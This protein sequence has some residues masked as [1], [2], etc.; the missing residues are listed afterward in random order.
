M[1]I[2]NMANSFES[3]QVMENKV[4]N[5]EKEAAI[6]KWN[7]IITKMKDKQSG[8]IVKSRRIRLRIYENSFTANEAVDWMMN[9]LQVG[10]EEAVIIGKEL[11]RRGFINHVTYRGIFEDNKDLIFRFSEEDYNEEQK[12][13]HKLARLESRKTN[14]KAMDLP[15]QA[16]YY[17]IY[18]NAV[19]DNVHII[20]SVHNKLNLKQMEYLKSLSS[21]LPNCLLRDFVIN[22]EVVQAP[23]CQNLF[24]SVLFA[25]I[26]GFTPLCEMCALQGARGV[27]TLTKYL[28]DYFGQMINLILNHG[29]D[30]VKF[31]GDALVAIFPTSNVDGLGYCSLLA[32]Q[33]A[34][35]MQEHLHQYKAGENLLTLH[36]GI[37]AGEMAAIV[38][39]GVNNRL[40]FLIAGN[41]MDQ[42]A[43]C[44]ASAK[45]G[46]VYISY[47]AASLIQDQIQL[48]IDVVSKKSIKKKKVDLL[49]DNSTCKIFRLDKII[50]S[51]PLPTSIQITHF[52][53]MKKC[54]VPFLQPAVLS[55]LDSGSPDDFLSE[56]RNV[57][58]VF[59]KIDLRYSHKNLPSLQQTFKIIQ[60]TILQFEGT[61][62]QFIID[63]KGSVAISAFGLPPLSHEDDPWRA[64]QASLMIM[65]KIDELSIKTSVGITT[66]KAFC[67]AVGSEERREYAMVGD[68][69]NLSARLMSITEGS[70][71]VDYSTYLSS[72]SRIDFVK[73]PAILF[74]GKTQPIDVY[75]PTKHSNHINQ[76]LLQPTDT[77]PQNK[78]KFLTSRSLHSHIYGRTQIMTTFNNL[79]QWLLDPFE[80]DTNCRTVLIEGEP[81]LG[82]TFLLGHLLKKMSKKKLTY[83][84][85]ST[86]SIEANTPYFVWKD[87]LSALVCPNKSQTNEQRQEDALHYLHSTLSPT[88][89]PYLSL[90]NSLFSLELKQSEVCSQMTD[91]LGGEMLHSLLMDLVVKSHSHVIVID[92]AQW[93]DHASWH[94]LYDIIQTLKQTLVVV[95]MRPFDSQPSEIKKIVALDQTL[96]HT[97]TPLSK[98]DLH[99]AACQKLSIVSIAPHIVDHLV[100]KSAGNPLMLNE[101]CE[102]L[103]SQRQIEI[104]NNGDCRST[105]RFKK[106]SSLLGMPSTLRSLITAKVDR[107]PQ[108]Q[109]FLLKAASVIGKIFQVELLQHL[110]YKVLKLE[111]FTEVSFMASLDA[112]ETSEFINVY[113][114]APLSYVFQQTTTLEVIYDL[115]LFSQ[116]NQIHQAIA[117]WLELHSAL[118]L[119]K[120]Y[121][122]LAHHY[123]KAQV[124]DKA[125][126]YYAQ[127]GRDALSK[128]AN[129]EALTF[130]NESIQL[131]LNL[132]PELAQKQDP[133]LLLSSYRQLGQAFYNLGLFE[134]AAQTLEEALLSINEPVRIKVGQE[135]LSKLKVDKKNNQNQNQNQNIVHQN[136]NPHIQIPYK[137]FASPS[138]K[139]KKKTSNYNSPTYNS[140]ITL[141]E[142][143]LILLTLGKVSYYSCNRQTMTYCNLQ[144][145]KFAE[146]LAQTFELC[147]AYSGCILTC[148]IHRKY[149]EALFYIELGRSLIDV[150]PHSFKHSDTYMNLL[151]A[152]GMY[153]TGVHEW[154]EAERLF[155]K[156]IKIAKKVGNSR[157]FEESSI[158]LS[159]ALFLQGKIHQSQLL[160][161]EAVVYAKKRGDAQSQVLAF[162]A[163]ARNWLALGYADKALEALQFLEKVV[164]HGEGHK[165]DVSNE[166]NFHA[167]M[168]LVYLHQQDFELA[169]KTAETIFNF[170]DFCEPTTFFTFTAYMTIP[171]VISLFIMQTSNLSGFKLQTNL[172]FPLLISKLEKALKHLSLFSNTFTFSEPRL[173]FW[174]GFLQFLNSKH[175]RALAIWKQSLALAK[176]YNMLYDQG[177]VLYRIGKFTDVKDNHKTVEEKMN[178]YDKALDIFS[179]IGLV[180][181]E[182]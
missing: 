161:Q 29:G 156:V 94:L 124:F 42:V 129:K 133:N 118:D 102:S 180:Y 117:E 139:F 40:E 45:P 41:P 176:K 18:W 23:S 39:G 28:N 87:M 8:I 67:G 160:T 95:A 154:N 11:Q 141:K 177:I 20:S 17:S 120:S 27:E 143:I 43:A 75:S 144:A 65:L 85:G 70:L 98:D 163:Q 136:S 182:L 167:L 19:H 52:K 123:G 115:M 121:P 134:K 166:I 106:H 66:G 96:C 110:V 116:K 162:T 138:Y 145:L 158:F 14:S 146:E 26:S 63:D 181:T 92:N 171:Q 88:F 21:Y 30:I 47:E 13:V 112:L 128:Y 57:S 56:L 48:S 149:Q 90:L 51:I 60:E 153:Y 55:H 68:V 170:I 12:V 108:N 62:R 81:G 97:L 151:Q 130:F 107:I 131:N 165:L 122:L 59:C 84:T 33:C 71:L 64:V 44:E 168:A 77:I 101:L 148:A 69:V 37:G 76:H 178:A 137:S 179:E 25:D 79:F 104:N 147:E 72:K 150:S 35:A 36:I 91:E 58:V 152:S 1:K 89:F 172:S 142:H 53:N 7:Q 140:N 32:A 46:Q 9:Q 111:T 169:Y 99:S 10:R 5:N 34:L 6:V 114:K 54:L 135:L 175:D 82:K 164:V 74:K 125:I 31:A 93:L 24:C 15:Q 155:E 4:L 109:Q 126:Y 113:S 73:L 127:S 103:L 3:E 105:P 100:L 22:G 80:K 173:I 78:S 38:V 174:Q 83:L 86:F 2:E 132:A 49:K 16:K 50:D 61:I 157:R 119:P 159:I